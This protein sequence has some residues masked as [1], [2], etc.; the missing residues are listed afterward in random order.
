MA[1]E[2]FAGVARISMPSSLF[3]RYLEKSRALFASPSLVESLKP[4]M[5]AWAPKT[6]Q[7]PVGEGTALRIE[8]KPARGG[9]RIN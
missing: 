9:W 3:A 8:V 2:V 4:V 7:L 5:S 6:D 1:H